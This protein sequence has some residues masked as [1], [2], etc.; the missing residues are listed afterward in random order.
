MF[1]SFIVIPLRYSFPTFESTKRRDKRDFILQVEISKY[2]GFMTTIAIGMWFSVMC[3][4]MCTYIYIL[5]MYDTADDQW[6]KPEI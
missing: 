4:K 3:T 1:L 5:C 6:L 2:I